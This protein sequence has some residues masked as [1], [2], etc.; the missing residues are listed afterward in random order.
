MRKSEQLPAMSTQAHDRARSV[1][2]GKGKKWY[3][4]SAAAGDADVVEIYIYDEIGWYGV[5][6]DEFVRELAQVTASTIHLRLNTPGGMVFEGTAIYNAL[7][8]HPARVITHIDGIAASMGSIIALAG[9]EV[10]IA[11]GAFVMIHDPWTV[12]IGGSADMRKEADL[13][14]KLAGSMVEIYAAKMSGET[15]AE[16]AKLMGEETW[17]TAAEAVAIGFADALIETKSKTA[18]ARGFNLSIFSHVPDELQD[19]RSK[20]R[21][22]KPAETVREFETF[23]RDAGGFSREAAKSIATGGY[24]T[25]SEPREEADGDADLMAALRKRG[26]AIQSLTGV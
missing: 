15:P 16:I 5:T 13:L 11:T 24:K 8:Q 3:R 10:R 7:L 18:E 17:W 21:P 6:A 9:D 20:A 14:D 19:R 22:P 2:A 25:A 12:A 23:L 26:E 1:T 4:I